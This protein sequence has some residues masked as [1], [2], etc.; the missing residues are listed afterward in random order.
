MK[1][2]SKI[3]WVRL[4][5]VAQSKLALAFGNFEFSGLVWPRF[6][7]HVRLVKRDE[8]EM[9]I[10]LCSHYDERLYGMRFKV[11][12]AVIAMYYVLLLQQEE[13][14]ESVPPPP[15]AQHILWVF[16]VVSECI[17]EHNQ[18]EVGISYM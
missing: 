15:C 7:G 12:D 18:L 9:K 6:C 10:I 5:R 1:E 3:G 13:S 16:R 2:R 14:R 4:Q 8:M 17:S 11:N